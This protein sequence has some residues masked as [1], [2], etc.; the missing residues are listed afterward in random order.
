MYF[1]RSDIFNLRVWCYMFL[2][3][4][5]QNQI[6]IQIKLKEIKIVFKITRKD[7]K[8]KYFCIIH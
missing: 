3:S 8:F 6:L 7:C 1:N 2:F 4:Y 5:F